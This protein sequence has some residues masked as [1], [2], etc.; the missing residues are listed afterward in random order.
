MKKAMLG[1]LA[2]F[3]LILAGGTG[4]QAEEYQDTVKAF[5]SRIQ[6]G[7]LEEA[8]NFIYGGSPYISLDSDAVRNVKTQFL[9]LPN[10]V[11]PYRGNE[12]ITEKV[13][14]GRYVYLYYFVMFDR[15]PLKFEFEFYKPVEKWILHSFAFD[16]KV[17][18]EI[19]QSVKSELFKK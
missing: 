6:E 14:V 16:D 9:S 12:L 8:V 19:I 18:D 4:V 17:N 13:V 5:F 3:A 15:Q 10:M 11:G 7:K 1:M 2:A